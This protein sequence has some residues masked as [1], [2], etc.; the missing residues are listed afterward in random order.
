MDT[1]LRIIDGSKTASFDGLLLEVTGLSGKSDSK[2]LAMNNID[3]VAVAQAGEEWM[4]I[5]KSRSGG[6]SVMISAQKKAEWENL[7]TEVRNAQATFHAS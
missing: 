7:V 3:S 1:P 2:R 4:F 6:F 5:V